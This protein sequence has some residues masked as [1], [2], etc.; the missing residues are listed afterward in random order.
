MGNDG[1]RFSV[2]RS[3]MKSLV[4]QRFKYILCPKTTNSWNFRKRER[5]SGKDSKNGIA[6]YLWAYFEDKLDFEISD[7]TL[8]RYNDAF[9]RDDKDVNIDPFILDKL[10]QYLEFKD[11]ADFCKTE[12]FTKINKDSSFTKVNVTFDDDEKSLTDKLSQIVINITTQPFFKLPEF[13]N[14][15]SGLGIIGVL[16]CAGFFGNKFYNT[17]TKSTE[18]KVIMDKVVLKETSNQETGVAQTVVYVP[19]TF[20][21]ISKMDNNLSRIVDKQCMFWNGKE[22]IEEDC[23][24]TRNGLVAIDLKLV[25]NFK[26]ITKPDTIK[27]IKGIWYSKYNNLIEFF[28]ADG[29]NP[30]N[31]KELHPL[32]THMLNKYILSENWLGF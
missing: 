30:E 20:A 19:Q 18:Q 13:I 5:E 8:V 11:F 12:N 15:Q 22:Y 29:I 17:E 25:D 7:K 21:N 14:K 26:K 27:S 9:L 1:L 31:N 10:S 4:L 3:V 32:T 24:D 28:T 16:A 6:L 2:K 23:N